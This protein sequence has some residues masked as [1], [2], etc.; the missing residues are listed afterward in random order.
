V[1]RILPLLAVLLC[2]VGAAYAAAPTAAPST[3]QAPSVRLRDRPLVELH[4]PRGKL[5]PETRARAASEAIDHALDDPEVQ[6]IR[7]ELRD[8]LAVVKAGNIFLFQLGPEDA[9]AAGEPNLGRYA[10]IVA[11]RLDD[12]FQVERRRM[13]IQA[14][15]LSVSLLV[16]AA[17][18]AFLALRWLEKLGTALEASLAAGARV[19]PLR[20]GQVEVASRR[21]M[22]GAAHVGLRVGRRVAQ[23]AVAYAWLLVAL[24]L[25]ATT[26]GYSGRLTHSVVR[27]AGALLARIGAA[28]P[29]LAVGALALLA[30]VLVVRT[31]RLFFGSVA[32]GETSLR[33]MP[34]ELAQPA[35][36][37]LRAVVIVLALL[38]AA[39]LVTGTDEGALSRLGLVTL[40]SIG[41][42]AA[43]L[44]ASVGVGL[45]T[46]F[47]RR[48]HPGEMVEVAGRR[49]QLRRVTLLD[50]RL[51]DP[52]GAELR[53]PHL[54]AFLH[55]ARA[56]G[57][58][59]RHSLEV[60]VSGAED[61]ARV[62]SVL[63]QAAGSHAS[64]ARAELLS[65]DARSARWHI[66]GIHPD[67]GTRVAAA[68]RDAGIALGEPP[69]GRP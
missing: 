30:L 56:L 26:R 10:G 55:P 54:L 50:I 3:P 46:V 12:A 20:L 40:L 8:D 18:I 60:A 35:G 11:R 39:P 49:G 7:A 32:R 25:F 31:I 41:L 19:P 45:P 17:L 14:A 37:L 33:W 53:I 58:L 27:P 24:S 38:F 64:G 61:Q 23:L 69:P 13:A 15:V 67:L 51:E 43:P 59:R 63:L 16:F 42:G 36:L 57:P 34:A 66:A 47:G 5:T 1:K 22:S 28:L 29:V 65:L 52:D 6:S 21:A 48:F 9:Q 44:L 68:L 62:E 4:V 2:S